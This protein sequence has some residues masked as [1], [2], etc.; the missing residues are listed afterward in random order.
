M[1]IFVFLFLPCLLIA[2]GISRIVGYWVTTTNKTKR[3]RI[4]WAVFLSAF[5]IEVAWFMVQQ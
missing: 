4:L 2:F 1:A 5:L 3:K